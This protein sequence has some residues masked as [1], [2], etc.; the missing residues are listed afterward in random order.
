MFGPPGRIPV[1]LLDLSSA[2]DDWSIRRR[3]SC[4]GQQALLQ[5]AVTNEKPCSKQQLSH[6][7]RKSPHLL[8]SQVSAPRSLPARSMKEILPTCRFSASPRLAFCW[9][10]FSTNCRMQWLLDE[11]ALAPVHPVLRLSLLI[12]NSCVI[13]GTCKK[14]ICL[15]AVSTC[16]Q[17]HFRIH[18]PCFAYLALRK[19]LVPASD[20]YGTMSL[21][22]SPCQRYPSFKPH[23]VSFASL[24]S[25]VQK[26]KTVKLMLS[27]QRKGAH[28]CS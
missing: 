28:L 11:S 12:S 15:A 9:P 21:A 8:L 2:I 1:S 14:A 6:E 20:S 7:Q 26:V 18:R 22:Q 27:A 13:C 5:W 24:L 25:P 4:R 23:V 10:C 19:Q 3:C 17:S 16:M